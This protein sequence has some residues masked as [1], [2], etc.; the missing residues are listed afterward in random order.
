MEIVVARHSLV[1]SEKAFAPVIRP[2]PP[3]FFRADD[4]VQEIHKL[5]VRNLQFRVCSRSSLG[6][7]GEQ[8][9]VLYA[10]VV[11]QVLD[12]W[13]LV[14][15]PAVHARRDIKDDV[16]GGC[17]ELNCGNRAVERPRFIAKPVVRRPQAVKADGKGAQPRVQE[18]AVPVP[19]QGISVG[20]ES[21]GKTAFVQREAALF[22]VIAQQR[23]TAR[24][25]NGRFMRINP[26][27]YGIDDAQKI[28]QRHIGKR[29][30]A[31]AVAAAMEARKIAPECAFPEKVAQIV[32]GRVNAF[33][34]TEQVERN[35]FTQGYFE[36]VHRSIE[37]L[38]MAACAPACS[39]RK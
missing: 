27:F 26:F 28:P 23:L 22:K 16:V 10:P 2:Y 36:A 31:K 17:R 35:A 25:G 11:E 6:K 32:D 14:E 19:R 34:D 7:H 24:D 39:L 33:L 29:C 15:I 4:K 20:D 38:V 30:V 18:T 5:P 3:Q 37:I 21:P 13:E 9:P 12:F 8:P 1:A